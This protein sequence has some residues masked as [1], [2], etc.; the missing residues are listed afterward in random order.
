MWQEYGGPCCCLGYW[1]RRN[2]HISWHSRIQRYS[3]SKLANKDSSI[4]KKAYIFNPFPATYAKLLNP[5]VYLL[6]YMLK[7]FSSFGCCYYDTLC[8]QFTAISNI[9]TTKQLAFHNPLT[10]I[11]HYS[12]NT[13]QW[14]PTRMYTY[15]KQIWT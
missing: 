6:Y 7:F 9:R 12:G 8:W 14:N 11:F 3:E 13:Q 5:S 2:F 10:A 4:Y 1:R 15:A